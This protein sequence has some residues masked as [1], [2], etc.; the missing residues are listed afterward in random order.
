MKNDTGINRSGYFAETTKNEA[1]R[2]NIDADVPLTVENSEEERD[3]KNREEKRKLSGDFGAEFSVE[4]TAEDD[5]FGDG[6]DNTER[7]E[8]NDSI[9]SRDE[10]IIADVLGFFEVEK[11]K[12]GEDG[13]KN[14]GENEV[15]DDADGGE[16]NIGPSRETAKTQL[17]AVGEPVFIKGA[18]G[19]F[20][21]TSEEAR[22]DEDN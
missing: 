20:K 11:W 15:E 6:G 8:S 9:D 7:E 4:E 5:F 1:H 18:F 22:G 17:F 2:E 10:E 3:E 12:I 13:G 21:G 16:A 14:D 19:G